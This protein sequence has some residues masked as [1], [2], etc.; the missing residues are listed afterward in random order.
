MKQQLVM[1]NSRRALRQ[2]VEGLNG[3]DPRL[4]AEGHAALVRYVKAWNKAGRNPYKTMMMISRADAERFS[5]PQLEKVW[6]L[7]LAPIGR[8]QNPEAQRIFRDL[9]RDIERRGIRVRPDPVGGAHW[10]I[11][12]TG[13]NFRDIAAFYASML[14]TNPLRGKLCDEPC[15]RVLCGKWFIK[16]RMVQKQCSRRCTGIVKARIRTIDERK[17]KH[18]QDIR[19]ARK[20]IREWR[21]SDGDWK[22][23]IS[24]RTGL[25]VKWV[26]RAVNKGELRPPS[27]RAHS[28][29]SARKTKG[30]KKQ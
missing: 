27:R 18:E 23:V 4:T 25:T 1:E 14:L 26:S 11:S 17:E 13:E 21:S 9:E 22:E 29:T 16:R 28:I 20:A 5:F 7:H 8:P 6:R 24:K 19:Q 15:Q 2:F 10:W 12:P 30:G 3:L